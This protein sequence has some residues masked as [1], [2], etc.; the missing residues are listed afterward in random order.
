LLDR[1]CGYMDVPTRWVRLEIVAQAGRI[2]FVSESGEAIP[3][4]AGTYEQGEGA[5]LI[6]IDRAELD[7]PMDVVGTIAH[8]LAHVRLLGEGRRSGDKFDNELL[9][10]LTVVH[11]GL[12]VFLANSPRNWMSQNGRWPGTTLIKPEYMSPP[13]FGWALAQLAYHRADEYSAWA[14]HLNGAARAVFREGLR[15]LRKSGDTSFRPT[16][17]EPAVL[18]VGEMDQKFRRI[19]ADFA[20][21]PLGFVKPSFD[22]AKEQVA[23][24]FDIK[25]LIMEIE[26]TYRVRMPLDQVEAARTLG[27]LWSV[28][29]RASGQGLRI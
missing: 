14:K 3:G 19:F 10:D 11:F 1:V 15:Y 22:L 13:M 21:L 16:V 29:V 8:E 18:E 7:R 17:R 28:V 6:R 4:A 2:G 23:P 27:E 12:G 24:D 9:T 26:E 5:A 25:E 20:E